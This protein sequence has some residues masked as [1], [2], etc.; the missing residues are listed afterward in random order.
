MAQADAKMKRQNLESKGKFE[1]S[2][3]KM[4][5]INN[6]K[7]RTDVR[8]ERLTEIFSPLAAGIQKHTRVTM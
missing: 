7:M 5:I 6:W 4:S 3:G 8:T 1:D 2:S